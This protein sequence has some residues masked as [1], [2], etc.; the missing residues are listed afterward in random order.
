MNRGRAVILAVLA[1]NVVVMLLFPPYDSFALGRGGNE[2]FDAFYFVLD[3]HFNKVVD[4]NLLLLELYWVVINAGIAWLLLKPRADGDQPMMR[5]RSGV[6]LLVLVNLA[7]VLLLPPFENYA[8]TLRSWGSYFDGFYFVFGDKWQRR[9]YVPLLYMEIVWIL[10]N[11]ALL[12][13]LLRGEPGAN[14]EAD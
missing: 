1:V 13:L 12:W 8:S 6:I 4:N 11:G 3:R 2:T 10:I 5:A 14:E 9:F 7:L